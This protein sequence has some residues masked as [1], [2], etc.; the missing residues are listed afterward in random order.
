LNRRDRRDGWFRSWPL[1]DDGDGRPCRCVGL[2]GRRPILR[3]KAD[4]DRHLSGLQLLCRLQFIER[5]VIPSAN[6]LLDGAFYVAV[7][8]L[9]IAPARPRQCVPQELKAV[10]VA[11]EPRLVKLTLVIVRIMQSTA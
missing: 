1:H 7:R 11:G 4:E 10:L 6:L 2:S 3:L 8:K 5:E 9:R